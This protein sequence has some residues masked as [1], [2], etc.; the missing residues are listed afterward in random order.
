MKEGL[1]FGS[2]EMARNFLSSKV[3]RGEIQGVYGMP[4]LEYGGYVGRDNTIKKSCEDISGNDTIS[5]IMT[6]E[7]F[8]F[9]L[10]YAFVTNFQ[11]LLLN[12]GLTT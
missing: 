5:M 4:C 7:Y 9:S 12:K 11:N 8:Y 2:L 3:N 10:I 1:Y 6:L